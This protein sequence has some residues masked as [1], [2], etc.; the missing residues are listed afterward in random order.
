[1]TARFHQKLGVSFGRLLHRCRVFGRA[2]EVLD[3]NPDTWPGSPLFSDAELLQV[4]PLIPNIAHLF[5]STATERGAPPGGP[6]RELTI[7]TAEGLCLLAKFCPKLKSLGAPAYL[8]PTKYMSAHPNLT[9]LGPFG[10]L[11]YPSLRPGGEGKDWARRLANCLAHSNRNFT[12]FTFAYWRFTNEELTGRRSFWIARAPWRTRPWCVSSLN[13]PL[14]LDFT[15]SAAGLPLDDLAFEDCSLECDTASLQELLRATPTLSVLAL[16]SCAMTASTRVALIEAARPGHLFMS[17][18]EYSESLT[19]AVFEQL[20]PVPEVTK[21]AIQCCYD[22]S[23]RTL[24]LLPRLFPNLS[25]LELDSWNRNFSG[26][27]VVQTCREMEVM[28]TPV[29]T[30]FTL[31]QL[32]SAPTP[33]PGPLRHVFSQNLKTVDLGNPMFMDEQHLGDFNERHR[34]EINQIMKSRSGA[35]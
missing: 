29:N 30:P 28:D 1:M 33:P 24:E 35:A 22:L 16:C 26:D 4:A 11:E 5:I 7:I 19:D 14:P 10:V 23:D 8:D 18:D 20:S 15:R 12:D 21:L 32:S 34:G 25:Q 2:Y 9:S 27:R 13:E 17:G 31:P 6:H 3:I